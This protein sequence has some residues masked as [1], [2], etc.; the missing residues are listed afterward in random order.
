MDM[1]VISRLGWAHPARWRERLSN[2]D[3]RHWSV[4]CEV[5]LRP[6]GQNAVELALILDRSPNLETLHKLARSKDLAG[7]IERALAAVDSA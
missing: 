4:G 7:L 6:A 1:A 5:L 2:P 3:M